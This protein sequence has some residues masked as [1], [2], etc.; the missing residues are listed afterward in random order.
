LAVVIGRC[1]VLVAPGTPNVFHRRSRRKKKESSGRNSP[2]VS[3]RFSAKTD[4][5]E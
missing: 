1:D 5:H 4:A 3:F 2:D